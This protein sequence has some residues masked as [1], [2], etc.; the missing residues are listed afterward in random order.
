LLA[1]GDDIANRAPFV[2]AAKSALNNPGKAAAI[3]D[4]NG[5]LQKAFV[6]TNAHPTEWAQGFS[7]NLFK[8]TLAEAEKQV[9]HD[10]AT[11]SSRW[12]ASF[13]LLSSR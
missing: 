11:A 1:E 2:V 3:A 13:S 8:L 6:Y 7:V 5:R 10:G 4:Y 12:R 9:A